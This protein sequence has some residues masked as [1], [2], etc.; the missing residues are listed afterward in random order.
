MLEAF[1]ELFDRFSRYQQAF[2]AEGRETAILELIDVTY[3]LTAY[4][5]VAERTSFLE[6]EIERAGDGSFLA[7]FLTELIFLVEG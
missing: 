2:E 1:P 4:D 6:G 7:D 5:T 3:N